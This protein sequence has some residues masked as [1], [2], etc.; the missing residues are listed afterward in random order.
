MNRFTTTRLRVSLYQGLLA[1][2][3]MTAAGGAFA[4]ATIDHNKALAGNITPGDA[5]GYPITLSRPGHYKL[6][7]NLSVPAGVN[8]IHITAPGVTL[9]L[10]GFTVAGAGSCT[11]NASSGAVT[12]ASV[13]SF[14][15]IR[16]DSHSTIVRNGMVRG[17]STGVV[18]SGSETLIGMAVRENLI[19]G[20]GAGGQPG[21]ASTVID[22]VFELNG[23][24]GMLLD[25]AL[26]RGVRVTGNGGAGIDGGTFTKVIDSMVAQNRIVGLRGVAARGTVVQDNGTNRQSV[27]SLGGNLDGITPF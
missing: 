6:M 16:N 9:D 15:G 14:E 18:G 24:Y 25:R 10:N 1:A 8:G 26:V 5:P 3:L 23:T 27:I 17:F 19:H 11:R 12:C 22:S 13:Y 20:Y 7:G 21:S 2:A 4:Q